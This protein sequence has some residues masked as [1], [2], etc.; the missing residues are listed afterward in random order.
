MSTEL[1][2]ALQAAFAGHDPANVTLHDAR[3][4]AVLIPIYPAPEPTLIFTVRSENLPS[5][6]GQISFPGGSIDDSDPSAEAAA[7]READEE[8]GLAP[9]AVTVVGCLDDMPTFVSGYVVSPVVG[10]LSVRPALTPNPAEVTE[11]LEVPLAELA[12]DIRREPGFTELGRSYPTEAW[13]WNGH[14]IWGVTARLL[15]ELLVR[16]SAV[17]LAAPPGETS[18]WTAWPPPIPTR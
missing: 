3:A 12:D 2:D 1:L 8:I 14:I 18:S 9:E 17:G 10:Y 7:L 15:R 4:A 13:V 11:I 6:K 5:H 16:L